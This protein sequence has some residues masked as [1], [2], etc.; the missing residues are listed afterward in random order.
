MDIITHTLV[1]YFLIN[2]QM[3][4][5]KATIPTAQECAI[6]AATFDMLPPVDGTFVPKHAECITKTKKA[7]KAPK[8]A[9]VD[10]NRLT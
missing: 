8:A 10:A 9:A 6:R 1:L 5:K 3:V 4:V 7:P 2:G